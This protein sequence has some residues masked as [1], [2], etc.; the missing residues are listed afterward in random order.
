MIRSNK[1][2]AHSGG[3]G[4][5]MSNVNDVDIYSYRMDDIRDPKIHSY[6]YKVMSPHSPNSS[7][8]AIQTF[9]RKLKTMR[10]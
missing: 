9:N 8:S 3:G 6:F 2:N 1:H 10:F 7:N 4:Y 5:N